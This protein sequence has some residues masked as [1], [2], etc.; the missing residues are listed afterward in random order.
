M[1]A[2]GH[3]WVC[4]GVNEWVYWGGET[5]KGDKKGHG[6][7]YTGVRGTRKSRVRNRHSILAR[8]NT[9][10]TLARMDTTFRHEWTQHF[11]TDGHSILARIDTAFWHEWTQHFGTNGHNILAR[12]DTTFSI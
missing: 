4:M 5:Q 11:G 1:G 2:D 10:F 6:W 7:A 9:S 3:G 8:A 12:I